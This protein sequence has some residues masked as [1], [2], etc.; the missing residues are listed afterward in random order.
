MQ[1]KWRGGR[2]GDVRAK[3]MIA[4]AAHDH[5]LTLTGKT[6]SNEKFRVHSSSFY[7]FGPYFHSPFSVFLP[8]VVTWEATLLIYFFINPTYIDKDLHPALT[9]FISYL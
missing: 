7:E 6:G 5:A 9:K 1:E 3:L 4:H 8:T 2:G